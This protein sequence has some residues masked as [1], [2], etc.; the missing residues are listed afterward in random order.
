LS[1]NLWLFYHFVFD[2][3]KD[4]LFL[5]SEVDNVG[6]LERVT[7]IFVFSLTWVERLSHIVASHWTGW[8]C[9]LAN[10][11]CRSW[12]TASLCFHVVYKFFVS[13]LTYWKKNIFVKIWVYCFLNYQTLWIPV[14]DFEERLKFLVRQGLSLSNPKAHF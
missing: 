12:I 13:W 10:G 4:H 1:Q 8:P 7:D 14:L 11:T 9:W 6:Q 2:V 3:I 5:R